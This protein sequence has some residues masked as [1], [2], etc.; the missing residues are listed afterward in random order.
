M[1]DSLRPGG[2]QLRPDGGEPERI[3]SQ[4]ELDAEDLAELARRS[5]D[6]DS[7]MRYP[8]R[9]P[10]AGPPPPS[11]IGA[12][13]VFWWIGAGAGLVCLAYGILNYGE[14]VRLLE[15]RLLPGLEEMTVKQEGADPVGQS[16]SLARLWVPLSLFGVP[17]LVAIGYPLLVGIAKYHSRNVRSLFLTV[18]VVDVLFILVA[19]D[20]LFRNGEGQDWVWWM[21]WVQ[22]AALVLSALNTLRRQVNE[23]L[24]ASTM[25]MRSF[26]QQ[27]KR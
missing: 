22:I 9:P 1:P 13:R 23:W 12:A 19:A 18:I 25:R 24:P 26:R 6:T 14:V 16:R 2:D 10:E 20:L 27:G 11:L 5:R 8:E 3:P 17:V 15:A 7:V 4:A 21:A